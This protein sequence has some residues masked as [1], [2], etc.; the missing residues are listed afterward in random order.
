MMV[1][2]W[3]NEREAERSTSMFEG[4][5][6]GSGFF[7]RAAEDIRSRPDLRGYFYLATMVLVGSTT[8]AAA[9]Y[10]VRELPIALVPVIRYSV[11]GVCVLLMIRG[12]GR[13]GRLFREDWLGLLW[14]A[15]MC[16]P[17]NQ[18]FFLAAARLGPTSHVGIFYA[19]APLVVLLGAWAMR[20]ERPDL[21]RLW[22]ILASVAG[23]LL[24]GVANLWGDAGAG[25]NSGGEGSA[26]IMADALLV[27]AVISW[28]LYIIVSKPLVVKHGALPVLAGAF[29]LGSVLNVPIAAWNLSAWPSLA[30]V[31]LT[32]WLALAFLA[33]FATP[34]GHGCQ[35][36]ALRRLDASEVANFSNI[37]PILTVVWGTLLFDEVVTP[38]LFLGG[39]L[40]VAGVSWAGRPRG[41]LAGP[42]S[43]TVEPVEVVRRASLR[44]RGGVAE[45]N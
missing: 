21:R 36:L 26:V 43:D 4:C 9:R 32:A 39:V 12:R 33:F 17:V 19:T 27:G 24:I 23:I 28:G 35:N 16:V 8:A 22:G 6:D 37:S 42:M 25:A 40:T 18:A 34:L 15:A 10:A 14:A 5:D 30:R 41:I 20:M 3:L 31:S 7:D 44:C 11:A 38:A 13:F 29:L 45:A 2:F 1:Q